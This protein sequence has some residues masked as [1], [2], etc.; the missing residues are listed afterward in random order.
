[1]S[2]EIFPPLQYFCKSLTKVGISSFL[3]VWKNLPGTLSRPELFFVVIIIVIVT[4]SISLLFKF[5]FSFLKHI[6]FIEV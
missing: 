2:K 3:N 5:S 6:Y 1:M 4:D